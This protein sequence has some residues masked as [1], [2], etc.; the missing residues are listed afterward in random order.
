MQLSDQINFARLWRWCRRPTPW[1]AACH[2]LGSLR[3]GSPSFVDCRLHLLAALLLLAL[4]QLAKAQGDDAETT[5]DRGTIVL[6][7]VTGFAAAEWSSEPIAGPDSGTGQ[8][9]QVALPD[10]NEQAAGQVTQVVDL[11]RLIARV[12]NEYGVGADLLAAVAAAESRF[13]PTA[14]SPKGAQ[15]LMQLMPATAKRFGVQDV[16]KVE[17]NLRGGAAYLRWLLDFFG[18]NTT[19]VVAAYNAGEQAVLKAGR[20]I[21]ALTETRNYVPRVLAWR[22]QYAAQF[23]QA[24]P[25]GPAAG[26]SRLPPVSS[27]GAEWGRPKVHA[28]FLDAAGL[29]LAGR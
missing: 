13:D 25:T 5:L 3:S 22:A 1:R 15:G 2:R 23:K 10:A 21:P 6:S 18:G 4:P 11:H 24:D 17:D 12:A 9:R 19:L 8:A 28:A 14:R 27:R 29:A 16:W 20:R 26:A 7:N